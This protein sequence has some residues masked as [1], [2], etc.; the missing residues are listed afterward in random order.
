MQRY[1]SDVDIEDVS[2]FVLRMN[3]TDMVSHT[4]VSVQCSVRV[5][6]DPVP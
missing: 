5:A 1:E 4:N 2:F 6:S 3:H